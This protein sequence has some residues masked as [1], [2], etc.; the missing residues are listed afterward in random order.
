MDFIIKIFVSLFLPILA[1][2]IGSYYTSLSVNTRYPTLKK[3]RLNPPSRVFWP[4]W[5]ILYLFMAISFYIIIRDGIDDYLILTGIIVFIVQLILNTLW[6]YLFFWKRKIKLAFL[7]II[8]LWITILVNI[9]IFF[10]INF[11]WWILLIPYIIWV[12]FATYLN[13]QIYCLNR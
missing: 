11:F 10:F 4:V 6:S 8:A 13:Y 2:W 1:A 9:I 5:T 7:D 3:P 12:S